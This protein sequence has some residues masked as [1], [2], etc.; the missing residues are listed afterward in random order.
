[1]KLSQP[2]YLF[3]SPAAMNSARVALG[4]QNFVQKVVLF[5]DAEEKD[6]ISF[7]K[8]LHDSKDLPVEYK[9]RR[10]NRKQNVA[11]MMCSSGTTGL[12]KGVQITQDNIFGYFERYS[13]H[14]ETMIGATFNYL[15]VIPW[16]HVYGALCILQ[17][18][19]SQASCVFLPKFK[20]KVFLECIERY[21]IFFALMV[22]TLLSW[23]AKTPLITNYNI[24]SLMAVLSSGATLTKDVEEA[25]RAR[26]N[27]IYILNTYGLSESTGGIICSTMDSNKPGSVGIVTPGV[28]IKVIDLVTGEALGPN[29][30]GEICIAGNCVMKGYVHDANSTKSLIKDGWIHTGDIGYYD[31][32]YMFFVVDRIKELIKYKG[33]QVPPAEI[34]GILLQHPKIA[35]AAVI[36]KD[37]VEAGELPTAFVVRDGEITQQ[38]IMDYVAGKV[39]PVKRLRGG[40]VFVDSIPKNENGKI[41]RRILREKLNGI[42]S[43]L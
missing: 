36:G 10:T 19:I 33:Y 16:S 1:M 14:S 41:L 39:S 28:Y 38:E 12:P 9:R 5:G 23:L 2:K 3:L 17:T 13:V 26:T 25:V 8:L 4:R 32:D 22:P 27:I 15:C 7:R 37:D 11:L 18:S 20:E 35:D 40:I 21:E 42:K 29:M 30:K 24:S 34:E 43:K 6:F 31:N